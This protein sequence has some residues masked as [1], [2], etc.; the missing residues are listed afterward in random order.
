MALTV[1]VRQGG[2]T[3]AGTADYTDQVPLWELSTSGPHAPILTAVQ[4]FGRASSTQGQFVIDD[5]ENAIYTAGTAQ[6]EAHNRVWITEDASGTARHLAIGRV[7]RKEA[8]R[9][10]VQMGNARRW[11]VTY[12]DQN[13]DLRGLALTADWDAPEEL[14]WQRAIRVI[15]TF[16]QTSPRLTTNITAGTAHLV[17][18]NDAETPVTLPAYTYEMGTSI[19]DIL[20]ECAESEGQDWGVV[21]HDDESGT[22]MCFQ[23]IDEADHTTNLCTL[24]IDGDGNAD[25]STTFAPI[26]DS[27]A[28]VELDGQ[29]VLSGAVTEWGDERSHSLITNSTY[30]DR[31]DYWVEK[32]QDA[33]AT[34]TAVAEARGVFLLNGRA[35]ENATHN[36]TIRIPADKAHLVRAGM[37]IKIRSAASRHEEALGGTATRRIAT[38]K[39]EL[40]SPS[41]G[42]V[43][44]IYDAHLQLD[45]P[46]KIPRTR[47]A[48]P[49]P[50]APRP[51]TPPSGGTP[52]TILAQW[53]FDSSGEDDDG[54]GYFWNLW[55]GDN[56]G[57]VQSGSLN[58]G[59]SMDYEVPVSA[60]TQ[61]TISASILNRSI[62]RNP[63]GVQFYVEY[64]NAG[65]SEISEEL[66]HTTSSTGFETFSVTVTTPVNTAGIEFNVP[67]SLAAVDNVVLSLTGSGTPPSGAEAGDI[68]PDLVD[69]P[70]D[71]YA[72]IIHYHH[73]F[74][75]EPPTA[76][77]DEADG[78]PLGTR[79]IQF[80]DLTTPTQIVAIYILQDDEEGAAVWF[81]EPA[82]DHVHDQDD[83][84]GSPSS[85][86]VDHS[87]MGATETFDFADGSD[88][89]GVL[90][91]DLTVTLDGATDGE[92]AFM[93]LV[94][95]QDGTGGHSIT[96][97]AAL[98]NR[99]DLE[100]AFDT[101]ASATNVLTV[102]TYDG[103]TTWYGALM[104]ATAAASGHYEVLMASGSAD[105]LETSDGLD[106][107]YVF[108]ED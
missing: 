74:R 4:A 50:R 53:H 8:E 41:V 81:Q 57:C 37:S 95:T 23:Y 60:S 94:L 68:S 29:E 25:S 78:L 49:G 7:E 42:S 76:D 45:K 71:V 101:T 79:W 32:M 91:D 19:N 15:E 64:I 85:G 88:H 65:G 10:A 17:T 86:V 100:A 89:E 55:S 9:G 90:D 106:W 98:I 104:G 58:P 97:P 82:P 54:N 103:G 26:W 14:A 107:L 43:K 77:D 16:C 30:V 62:S 31:F 6:I 22:H 83:I 73:L 36:L 93:T 105:P 84:I 67:N 1:K 21:L 46:I 24:S 69:D 108:V 40:V 56:G 102:F 75:D 63:A 2:G 39:L 80:D 51:A 47:R 48:R 11:T 87:S 72:P 34:T 27:G 5:D 38:V 20:G 66:I 96:L 70:T 35:K 33:T 92:A 18:P 28:A 52:D 12:G 13:Q 59:I 44:G 3:A 99:S 61:Y